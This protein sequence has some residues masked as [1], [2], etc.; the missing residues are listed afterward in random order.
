M[1]LEEH[2]LDYIVL[3]DQ[4]Q[5]IQK[6]LCGGKLLRVVSSCSVMWPH[7]ILSERKPSE[8]WLKHGS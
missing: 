8:Q 5:G 7:A 3:R 4:N 6:Q 1:Y 2:S